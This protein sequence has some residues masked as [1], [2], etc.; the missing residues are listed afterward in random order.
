MTIEQA[1]E[2]DSAPGSIDQQRAELAEL[3]GLSEPVSADV[4]LSAVS[5]REYAR[6][7]L[8][9][10]D[11]PVML[12][13]LLANPPQP[14]TPVGQP[15]AE[16]AEPGPEHSTA[17]LLTAAS[18]SFWAWTKSGFAVVDEATYQRRYGTCLDC[19][20]LVE[21]PRKRIYQIVGAADAADSS[22]VCS[23]CGCVASKKARLPHESCPAEH[24]ELAGMTRWGEPMIASSKQ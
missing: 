10:K 7:L 16:P 13:F 12:N 22:K 8:L 20:D 9:C 3:L 18:K 17:Q 11:A 1:A 21:P 24:A 5:D 2:L 19:P 23:L 4:L 6:N 15:V 14:G